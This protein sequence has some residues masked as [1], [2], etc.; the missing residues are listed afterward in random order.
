MRHYPTGERVPPACLNE[1]TILAFTEGRLPPGEIA[2]VEAHTRACAG[3]RDLLSLAFESRSRTAVLTGSAQVQPRAPAPAP[4][5]T[6]PL[7]LA[8]GTSV[9]R[10]TVLALLGRGGMGEVYSAYDPELDRKIALKLLLAAKG[11]G[12]ARAQGRLLR[13]AKAIARL[14]HANVIVVHDAGTFEDRVFVAMEFVDGHTAKEWLAGKPRTRAE[15]LDVFVSAARGLGAAHAAGL[16]HR[17]FKPHN[18]MVG[19]DGSVR[20]MDFGLARQISASPEAESVDATAAL[21]GA[22]LDDVALTRTGEIVGTPLY[23]AP[24]QFKAGPTD[25]RTDQFSFC[26]ALYQALYAAHPFGG[27]ALPAL[28]ADVLAGNVHPAPP[29]Q[30]VPAWLRRVLLRGLSPDPAA[31]WPSMH[32]L[33]AALGRDPARNRR[34]WAIAAGATLLVAAAGVTLVRGP[35]R[36]ES[37]CRGGPARLAGIWEPADAPAGTRSRQD[38]VHAAFLRTGRASAGETWDRVAP[39]LDS[40]AARWLAMYRDTCE[41]THVRGE[42]SA[43]TLDLRMSCLDQR[44][45]ALGALTDVLS[46]ADAVAVN[47]AVDAANALPAIDGCADLK[48]LRAVVEP[49][50]DA[51]TR[52]R[53]DDLRKRLATAKALNDT[54]KEAE[55]IKQGA[56][57]ISEARTIGYKPLLAEVLATA[58]LFQFGGTFVP[59]TITSLEEAVWMSLATRRDD[60]AAQAASLLP[61][62]V[63]YYAAKHE[64]GERWA[65]LANAVLDRLGDGHDRV[66][67]WV[68]Q[69]EA[70]IKIQQ[71]HPQEAI[72]LVTRALALEKSLPPD[73]PDIA[74][75][76]DIQ[77]DALRQMGRYDEALKINDRVLAVLNRAYGPASVVMAN[78]LSSRGEY[79]VGLGRG[80]EAVATFRDSLARW[81]AQMGPNYAYLAYPLTGLGQALL[82]LGKPADAMAPLERALH[83]RE[84][85]GGDPGLLAE[86][87]FALARA[88]SDSGRDRVRAR[89]L[90]TEAREA[91]AKVSDK[92]HT[93]AIDTWLGGHALGAAPTSPPR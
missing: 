72:T 23:M 79:L 48:L 25:A 89:A 38:V 91:Y 64:E 17:D 69:G 7:T 36:A 93:T 85:S 9:G 77:A 1:D 59:E 61:T 3:C 56:R 5:A 2:A 15:I 70:H 18:V 31:R 84:T 21:E 63:G 76:L 29:K 92:A 60:L 34:R 66:R 8:R 65:R 49:P 82:L 75:T 78:A 57:L 14:S 81:E 41:A 74:I 47:S 19:K 12:D 32:E 52:A 22:L 54:G 62:Y 55:A 83:F 51:A 39:L 28:I 90:A 16:V 35:R 30:D 73:H 26:V 58:G 67:A 88:L 24:E 43:E 68:L 11:T 45:V 20:V 4:E 42:Q 46:N 87:R 86:T 13:E 37:L 33:I 27:T 53:V 44:R 6:G 80:D 71:N 40:Y 10:Y 50:R